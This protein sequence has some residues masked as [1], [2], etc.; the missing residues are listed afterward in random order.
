MLFYN[1]IMERI[2]CAKINCYKGFTKQETLN[3]IKNAGFNYVEISTSKGN[4][5]GLSQDMTSEELATFKQEL[6]DFG[7]FPIAI[8]GNS[9]L[10]DDDT[11]KILKN[12]EMGHYL[13]SKYIDTTVFNARNDAGFK[14]NEDEVIRHIN[15]YIPYLEKYDLD[16]VLELH[17]E[18]ARGEILVPIL[19]KVNNKHIHINYDTANAIYCGKL[20]VDEM[21]NDF[22][23]SMDHISFMHCKEKAGELDVW[24]FPALGK[25]YVP[26][27]KLFSE[28]DNHNNDATLSVEIEFT[29]KGVSCVEEVD[30]ALIDSANYLKS[31]NIKL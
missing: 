25:G 7:L 1:G 12:I 28:L 16:L 8:G 23:D 3:G 13:G 24:N 21:V 10:M 5:L 15:F 29:D 22:K 27:D 6:S 4:S 18:Y 11:S 19:K 9:Y 17:G 30:Q 31:L 2:V 26:F 20:T 14:A